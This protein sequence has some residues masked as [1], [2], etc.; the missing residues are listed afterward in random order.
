MILDDEAVIISELDKQYVIGTKVSQLI[1][2]TAG[3]MTVEQCL[4]LNGNLHNLTF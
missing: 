2:S 4:R 3:L 1:N